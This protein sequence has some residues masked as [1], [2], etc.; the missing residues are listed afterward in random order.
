MFVAP[1]QVH[2]HGD[3]Q[4]LRLFCSFSGLSAL[5]R[6]ESCTRCTNQKHSS[7]DAPCSAFY[8]WNSTTISSSCYRK[9]ENCDPQTHDSLKKGRS[10]SKYFLRAANHLDYFNLL[11]TTQVNFISSFIRIRLPS[12][13]KPELSLFL[14]LPA[15]LLIKVT[16]CKTH[17]FL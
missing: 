15:F 9:P 14:L 7:Q 13:A 4:N 6:A 1:T 12:L 11:T 16:P 8:S 17:F 2:C 10:P 5:V 3:Y